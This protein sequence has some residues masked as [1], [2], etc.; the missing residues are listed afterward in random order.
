M[1]ENVT[2]GGGAMSSEQISQAKGII[3]GSM[4]EKGL[5]TDREHTRHVKAI[6]TS[7]ALML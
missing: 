6:A 2:Y 3:M 1:P 7:M 4:L 5:K